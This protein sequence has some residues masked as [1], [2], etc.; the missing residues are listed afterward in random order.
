MCSKQF[1][2]EFSKFEI[3]LSLSN[4]SKNDQNKGKS[5]SKKGLNVK[6]ESVSQVF[7]VKIIRLRL[8]A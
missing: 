2:I 1:V 6:K 8:A 5:K 4:N 3:S 7:R